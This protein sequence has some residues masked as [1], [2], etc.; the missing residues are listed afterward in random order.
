VC[1]AANDGPGQEVVGKVVKKK[2]GVKNFSGTVENYD[3][4][5][6]WYRVSTQRG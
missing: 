4:E 5:E 1:L 3:P 2:F 6:K